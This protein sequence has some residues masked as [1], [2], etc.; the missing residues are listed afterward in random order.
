MRTSTMTASAR[1]GT[2]LAAAFVA[3]GSASAFAADVPAR[4]Y[5]KAPAPSPSYDWSGVYIGG[6]V[7]GASLST[8]FKDYDD[9]FDN[10][11]LSPDRK[12]RFTGGVYGGVNWQFG[13][14]V[15]GVDAQWSYYNATVESFPFGEFDPAF[16]RVKLNS[17]GSVKGRFGLAFTDTL[18]YVAAGPAWANATFS[19]QDGAVPGS[20]RRTVNGLAAAAGVEHM[21][22]PNWIV[23]GQFQYAEYET[24]KI[25]L[26]LAGFSP[27]FG[28][29]SSVLEATFG[30][31]YKIGSASVGY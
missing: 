10:Q 28:Q 15:V 1:L 13:S 12:T 3:I 4:A 11:G 20:S 30:V 5:T 16:L 2:A 26:H 31:S 14:F 29:Q 27:R 19:V 23:R 22:T 25:N 6:Q 21:M 9:E 18:V 8:Q 7:G 17:A 24:Q